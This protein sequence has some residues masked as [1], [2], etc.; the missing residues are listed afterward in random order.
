M[1]LQFNNC[2]LKTKNK[3]ERSL[4]FPKALLDW[5]QTLNPTHLLINNFQS[6]LAQHEKI[7]IIIIPFITNELQFFRIR[8]PK[9]LL[10]RSRTFSSIHILIN[11]I[12]IHVSTTFENFNNYR[13]VNNKWI[14]ISSCQISKSFV[15]S[16]TNVQSNSY[17]DT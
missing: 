11:K 15:G 10:D 1:K 6:M 12:S 16:I 5:S 13:I 3:I 4:R 17:F 9:A 7:L 14:V 8:Y 2:V